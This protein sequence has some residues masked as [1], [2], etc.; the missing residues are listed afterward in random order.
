DRREFFGLVLPSISHEG[1]AN[2]AHS[3]WDDFFAYRGYVA[4]VY[5]AGVEGDAKSR[6][7]FAASRD[8]FAAD[9]AASVAAT[10]AN[11]GIDYVPG[12]ADFG[13]F[14]ATSTT[15]ALSPTGAA[16][17]LPEA[18]LRRTFERYWG[19]FLARRDS[20]QAWDAFTPYE[21]RAIGAF[22]RL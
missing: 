18:A 20:A 21:T 14:D 7:R 3:Y 10:M 11:H 4:A 13:D 1:Y 12:S 5:L 8:T 17:L 9:L 22:V 15:V 19:S 6:R 16:D 2:P